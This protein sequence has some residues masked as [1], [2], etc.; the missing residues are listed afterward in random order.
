MTVLLSIDPGES[1]GYLVMLAET[2]EIVNYGTT[3]GWHM[4]DTLMDT[5]R[6]DSIIL[7][8]FRLY[9][10]QSRV[11]I[12][13]AFPAVQVIGAVRYMAEL[14]NIL[15]YQQMASSVKMLIPPAGLGRHEQDAWRHAEAFRRKIKKGAT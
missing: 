6:P 10:H 12:G 14:R 7:E 4:L 8:A 13:S 5:H 9:P 11:Q 1:T 3:D 15:V 2:G